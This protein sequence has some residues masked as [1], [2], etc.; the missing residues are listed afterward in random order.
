MKYLTTTFFSL[1]LLAG[2]AVAQTSD[3]ETRIAALEAREAI[4]ELIHGYG[5]ALDTRDFNAFADLFEPERGTWSGGFGTATGRDEIFRMMDQTIGHAD[6]PVTPSSHHVFTNIR[7]EVDG[8]SA[9]GSTK[10]TFV[11]P[12]ED[13]SPEWVYL[14]HYQD[15]FV[16]SG[17]RW[18]FL[19]REA[20]TDIPAQQP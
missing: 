2:A 10:W 16:R 18:Y 1:T 3:L 13:G 4:R 6:P 15:S 14:G 5:Q 12:A 9:T 8:D 17:G 11:M 7:I 19:R 20:F